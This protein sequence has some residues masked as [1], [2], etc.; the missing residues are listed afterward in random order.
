LEPAG[1]PTPQGGVTVG[2]AVGFNVGFDVG[3]LVSVVGEAEVD[4][5]DDGA[6]SK[7]SI[8]CFIRSTAHHITPLIQLSNA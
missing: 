8:G 7:K 6:T 3:V 2:G 4:G 5:L 1:Q